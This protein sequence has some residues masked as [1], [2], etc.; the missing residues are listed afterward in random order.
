MPEDIDAKSLDLLGIG[1]LAK[2]IPPKVYERTAATLLKTFEQVTAPI[3]ATTEGLGRYLHQKFSTMVD[4]EKAIATYTIEQAVERA[5]ARGALSAPRHPKT[6]VRA[7]EEASKETDPLLHEMWVN[8]LASQVSDIDAGHPHFVEL[9]SH[10]SPAEARLLVSL[11]P[12]TEIRDH[13]GGYISVNYEAFSSFSREG[14]LNLVIEPWTLS[15]TLLCQ[16]HLADTMAPKTDLIK[17]NTILFRTKLGTA[18]LTAVA[19]TSAKP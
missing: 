12:E 16:M 6:F 1:K 2:A 19:A 5:R 14:G 7:I 9:L 18:F 15:C 10:F 8:L 4:A 17:N 11:K 13:G 3:T